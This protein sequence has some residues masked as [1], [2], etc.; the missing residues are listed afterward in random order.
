[1]SNFVTILDTDGDFSSSSMPIPLTQA[2]ATAF[3]HAG[4]CFLP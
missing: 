4:H 1:M 2:L 3:V